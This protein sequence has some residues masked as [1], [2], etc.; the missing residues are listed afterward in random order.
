MKGWM[1]GRTNEWME[2]W[3]GWM[4]EDMVV[5]DISGYVKKWMDRR[6][7]SWV[8]GWMIS[9]TTFNIAHLSDHLLLAPFSIDLSI[10]PTQLCTLWRLATSAPLT[11]LSE[12]LSSGSGVGWL[13]RKRLPKNRP[14]SESEEEEAEFPFLWEAQTTGHGLLTEMAG[15]LK[16]KCE[17]EF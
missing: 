4:A 8:G 13:L 6:I 7:G 11:L 16:V 14:R 10:P 2:G 17:R 3:M 15:K 1:D 5:E 12:E 9:G